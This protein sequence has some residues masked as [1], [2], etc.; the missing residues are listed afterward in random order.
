MVQSQ[1]GAEEIAADVVP[2]NLLIALDRSC[3]MTSKVGSKSKWQ[4]AVEALTRLFTTYA[5]QIRFGLSLFPDLGGNKCLQE[6]PL[7]ATIQLNN[8][9]KLTTLLKSS[10]DK[11]H[12]LYPDGP[13]VTNIDTAMQQAAAAPE[14][15]DSTRGNFVLL[16]TDGKQAGCNAAGGDSGTTKIIKQMAQATI[17]TFVVGFGSGVDPDQLNIFADAGGQPSGDPKTHYFKAEDQTD[18]EQA[19]ANIAKK[20]IGCILKLKKAPENL[21]QLYVFFDKV[22]VPKDTDHLDGWDYDK[23]ANQITFYGAAC[24][25][26]NENQVQDLDIVYGCQQPLE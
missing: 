10:L 14:L 24:T 13:C 22:A 18:L 25:K 20:T 4:I 5:G 17:D 1:C 21:Q 2:P 16:I 26:L 8:E 11:A 19:L 9:S 3:S 7:A 12:E 6:D 15:K 23:T